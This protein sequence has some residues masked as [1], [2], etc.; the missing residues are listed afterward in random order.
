VDQPGAFSFAGL[1]VDLGALGTDTSIINVVVGSATNALLK[2]DFSNGDP[3]N[4]SDVNLSRIP[5]AGTQLNLSTNGSASGT[6][7][8]VI[9]DDNLNPGAT[10]TGVSGTVNLVGTLPALP[11]VVTCP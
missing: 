1:N 9:D 3:A 11:P 8:G 4:F 5:G 10:N 7:A 6:A 2:N